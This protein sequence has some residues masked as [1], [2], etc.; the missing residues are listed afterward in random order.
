MTIELILEQV[1][2]VIPVIQ[3]NNIEDALPTARALYE[4]GLDSLEVTLRTPCA[5]DA[6]QLIKQEI[7]EVCVG[8]GTVVMPEQLQLVKDAGA[9]FAVSPGL[10][11]NLVLV[12]KQIEL[13]YLPGVMTPSEITLAI[14]L[15][16][17][18]LK[19]FPA[20]Q[21][22]GLKML[23]ALASPFAD[24]RFCPTGGI[25]KESYEDFLALDNVICVGGSWLAP[26]KLVKG[27][28]WKK[29]TDLARDVAGAR[30]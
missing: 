12:A 3:I 21:A 29:I 30:E 23:S 26:K 25:S 14:E 9:E 1:K 6:I 11:A 10:N 27:E 28:K 4:G 15:G 8:A 2:S 5:L 22:G 7:P 19:F 16:L 20:E 17:K 18:T 13:P 24:I